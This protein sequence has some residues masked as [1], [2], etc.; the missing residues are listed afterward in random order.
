MAF[1][2]LLGEPGQR[3]ADPTL[4][5]RIGCAESWGPSAALPPLDA[6]E[7]WMSIRLP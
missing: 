1:S 3:C 6:R 5:R 2:P 4:H 7:L